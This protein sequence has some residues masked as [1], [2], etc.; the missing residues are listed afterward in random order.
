ME[1]KEKQYQKEYR[2]KNKDKKSQYSKEYYLKNKEKLLNASKHRYKLKSEEI[3]T[4]NIEWQKNNSDRTQKYKSKYRRKRLLTEFY[5]IDEYCRGNISR[6]MR[7]KVKGGSDRYLQYI[8]IDPQGLRNHIEK[9][10]DK[11]M[12]WDNYA[13]IWEI[14]HIIP[15]STAKDNIDEMIKLHHYSNLRPLSVKDNRNRHWR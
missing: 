2:E 14:D 12:N 9:Q 15:I 3:I 8:G 11:N 1:D 4:K 13:E 5:K 10:F 6:T 7:N